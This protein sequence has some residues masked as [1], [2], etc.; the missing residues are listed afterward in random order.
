MFV[1]LPEVHCIYFSIKFKY[2]FFIHYRFIQTSRE[3]ENIGL[4]EEVTDNDDMI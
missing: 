4:T 2:I 1:G 3:D